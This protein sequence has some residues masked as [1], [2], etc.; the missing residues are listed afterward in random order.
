F[1]A[2]V[3][4]RHLLPVHGEYRH[5]NAHRELAEARGIDAPL[6]PANGDLIRLDGDGLRLEARHPQTPRIVN[7]DEVL[8]LEGLAA[9]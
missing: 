2:W 4:P 9:P 8:P 1:Y 7:Q 6:I 5:Q 3:E